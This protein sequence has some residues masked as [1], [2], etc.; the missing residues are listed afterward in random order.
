MVDGPERITV[1]FVGFVAESVGIDVDPLKFDGSN[2][3]GQYLLEAWDDHGQSL[4]VVLVPRLALASMAANF[5]GA[6][7]FS[8][9]ALATDGSDFGFSLRQVGFRREV[10]LPIA[11]SESAP[12]AA[13][14][15]WTATWYS[16]GQARV[17]A[18]LQVYARCAW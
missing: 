3:N 4:G 12:A 10:S 7:R 13:G 1:E 8:K 11:M 6:V 14:E 5:P 2:T 16:A 9:V 18:R 15:G 17:A